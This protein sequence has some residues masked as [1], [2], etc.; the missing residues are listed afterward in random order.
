[1]A[2]TYHSEF[3]STA[4]VGGAGDGITSIVMLQVPLSTMLARVNIPPRQWI[5]KPVFIKKSQNWWTG[6]HKA[7]VVE[8]EWGAPRI[9]F[10]TCTSVEPEPVWL[11]RIRLHLK[12]ET[13]DHPS[14]F[15]AR[16]FDLIG[17]V[18]GDF[19]GV[20]EFHPHLSRA[21]VRTG[22]FGK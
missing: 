8:L 3:E 1:M 17:R 6:N 15:T 19:A 21:M 18:G 10:K 5:R 22:G 16:L 4:A 12:N 20:V 7:E 9:V 11:R 13:Y 14:I 2:R